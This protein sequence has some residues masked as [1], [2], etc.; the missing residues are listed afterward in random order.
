[1]N[2]EI[3]HTEGV[4]CVK[5]VQTYIDGLQNCPVDMQAEY[6]FL[7]V[8]GVVGQA[9]V[10]WWNQERDDTFADTLIDYEEVYRWVREDMV[11][12]GCKYYP[13][14]GAYMLVMHYLGRVLVNL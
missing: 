8:N 3:V 12:Q 13:E 14:A 6:A 9:F 1:M 10:Y 11:R 7:I 4:K 2:R 5:K